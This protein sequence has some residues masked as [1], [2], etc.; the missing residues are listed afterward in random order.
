MAKTLYEV[1]DFRINID[2]SARFQAPAAAETG[3]VIPEETMRRMLVT[4]LFAVLC[5]VSAHAAEPAQPWQPQAQQ[6]FTVCFGI[7]MGTPITRQQV[8]RGDFPSAELAVKV[9]KGWTPVAA[10]SGSLVVCK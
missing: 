5:A 2:P 7:S 6:A 10:S 3:R 9:P 1:N 4:I 8:K